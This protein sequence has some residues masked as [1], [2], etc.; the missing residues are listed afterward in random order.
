MDPKNPQFPRLA[1][2]DK[3]AS[4]YK[5]NIAGKIIE[6]TGV[7]EYS[8]PKDSP[9]RGNDATEGEFAKQGPLQP[10]KTFNRPETNVGSSG[11]G[12]RHGEPTRDY[13]D[14]QLYN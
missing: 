6:R 13:L 7:P 10:G 12:G 3:P 14:Y 5:S 2:G 8:L 9:Y 11:E 4:S 1:P